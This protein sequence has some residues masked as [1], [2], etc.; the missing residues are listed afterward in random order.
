[1]RLYGKIGIE[2]LTDM[3]ERF[4]RQ[5]MLPEIGVEGQQKLHLSKVLIVGVGG[6]G[7]PVSLYLAAA[8][9][10]TI[11][12][13]DHDVVSISNLQRQILYKE[14]EVGFEKTKQAAIR[15]KEIS[16]NT[17]V[18]QYNKQ[19]NI[20]NAYDIIDNYD[21]VVDCSDNAATR[22]LIDDVCS[23]QNKPFVYGAISE[24]T[25]QVSVFD[26]RQKW[27][28]CDLYPDKET[29]TNQPQSVRGVIGSLP[30]IIGSVQA[31]EAI[32][33]ITGIGESLVGC[34]FTID[35]RTMESNLLR[36]K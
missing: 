23:L 17:T 35:I 34:I 6:L 18:I 9:I 28:Y 27:R 29:A 36:C 31:T 25:G 7:S 30:G 8:G 10:G 1:M 5:I 21:F 20:E 13:I 32:K 33:L 15:I 4:S 14:C 11:G 26:A 24:Y 12:L 16:T 22:Y 3:N 19:L 2:F